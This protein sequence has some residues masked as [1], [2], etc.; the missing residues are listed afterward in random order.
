MSES[1]NQAT[2]T[3]SFADLESLIRRVVREELWRILRGGPRF[4]LDDWSQEGPDDP[5]GDEE[6][7]AEAVELSEQYRRDRTGWKTLAEFE[8]E[9]ANAETAGEL[10][11]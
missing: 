8:S 11:S 6:L 3:I 1:T 10:A 5:E 4:I 7:A 2:L 9:L